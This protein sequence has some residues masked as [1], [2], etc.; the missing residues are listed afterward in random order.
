MT[1]SPSGVTYVFLGREPLDLK[2]RKAE[3][4]TRC[5]IARRDHPENKIVIGIGM[6][7]H[8]PDQGYSLELVYISMEVF[9]E[10]P[11]KELL[12][13]GKAMGWFTNPN[14]TNRHED[15]FPIPKAE[16]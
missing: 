10:E 5:L 8:I 3:L 15:E 2:S 1:F 14:F 11:F 13:S 12:E 16:K 4:F 6:S 9:D 7:G